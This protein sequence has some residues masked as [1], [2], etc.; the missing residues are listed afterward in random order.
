MSALPK[1][2][3]EM[4]PIEQEAKLLWL[5]GYRAKKISKLPQMP[6]YKTIQNWIRRFGWIDE[7]QNIAKEAEE[8]VKNSVLD[9]LTSATN[10]HLTIA[11]KLRNQLRE[12]A[13]FPAN[14]K[15]IDW[16]TRAQKSLVQ[17]EQMIRAPMGTHEKTEKDAIV[18]VQNLLMLVHD[19]Q[20][21][22]IDHPKDITPK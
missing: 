6:G 14:S 22:E 2:T 4:T 21:Q 16:L 3:S 8:K 20:Q 13:T 19:Y 17:T 18:G 15:E 10:E 1:P 7:Y 9:R 12:L 11:D 5:Q